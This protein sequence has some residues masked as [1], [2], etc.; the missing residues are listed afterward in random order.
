MIL[1]SYG[2]TNVT[3][4]TPKISTNTTIDN[5]LPRQT[6]ATINESQQMSPKG[7]PKD[8]DHIHFRSL[9]LLIFNV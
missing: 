4:P 1:N 3:G 9:L 2:A 8:G 7:R 5:C 6:I